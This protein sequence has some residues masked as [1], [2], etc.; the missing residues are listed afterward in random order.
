[1]TEELLDKNL[2]LCG[3][4]QKNKTFVPPEFLPSRSR[5]L[6]SSIFTFQNE[7]TLVS[8]VTNPNKCVILLSTEHHTDSIVEGDSAMKPE[9]IAH[10]N[11]TKGGVDN[12]DRMIGEY[13]CQRQTRRWPY[14]LFMNLIDIAAVNAF[15]LWIH[16]HPEWNKS[17]RERRRLFLLELGKN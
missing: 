15:V 7:V 2:T 12:L 9:I 16:L 5:P 3:T 13:T 4:I 6:H 14:A 17:Y 10:Y 8:Y 11:D 1:M